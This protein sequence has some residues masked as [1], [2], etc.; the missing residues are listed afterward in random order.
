MMT[1]T[2]LSNLAETLKA[3]Q[4]IA[5][6]RDM[7]AT[8]KGSSIVVENKVGNELGSI[9]LDITTTNLITA[10]LDAF[11]SV[12]DGDVD[13]ILSVEKNVP[14]VKQHTIFDELSE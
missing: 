12:Y 10:A 1:K 3:L 9:H 6:V 4:N 7:L 11:L 5:E 14:E 8:G 13:S 2:K